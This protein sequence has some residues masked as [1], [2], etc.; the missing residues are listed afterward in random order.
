MD[1][2]INLMIEEK[3]TLEQLINIDNQAMNS[4]INY[5]EFLMTD[6]HKNPDCTLY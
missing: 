1:E 4:S 2:L 6:G 5:Q 3:E